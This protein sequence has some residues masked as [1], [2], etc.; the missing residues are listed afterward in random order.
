MRLKTILVELAHHVPFSLFSAAAGMTVIALVSISMGDRFGGSVATAPTR[1]RSR[2]EAPSLGSEVE[3]TT[4]A[5]SGGRGERETEAEGAKVAHELLPSF[6]EKMFHVFHP[7]HIFLS[8]VATTAMF[9]RFDRRL[10]R[11]I[12]TGI[13]GSVGICGVSDIF[14]P[15]V[16]G[17][18]SGRRMTLHVCVVEHPWLILPSAAVGVL[19]GI[20]AVRALT[21]RKSTI[22]SHSS[23]VFVSSM[24][25]LLYLI[26]FGFAD[27]THGLLSVFAIVVVAVVVPCCTSDI[28]FPLLL[29]SSEARTH[30]VCAH[31]HSH[32]EG[33]SNH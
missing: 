22:F 21:R 29:A 2:T 12:L 33:G 15:F 7:L 32:E 26:S 6:F 14:F 1:E 19:A 9:W 30:M 18:A 20:V 3:T 16:G 8:A 24:A 23:H 13:V 4:V 5:K 10:L 31:G 28:V 25:S 11:A 27:W 17:L